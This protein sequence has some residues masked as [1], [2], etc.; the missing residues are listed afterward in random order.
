MWF[1]DP[2]THVPTLAAIV[3]ASGVALPQQAQA[4]LRASV[5]VS[6]LTRPVAFI[7]EPGT[8]RRQYIVEQDGWVRVV[9]DGALQPT[10]FLDV[11]PFVSKGGERGLLGLAFAPDYATTGRLWV[12]FTNTEGHTV[13]A[14][15]IRSAAEPLR[16]DSASRVDLLW[17]DGRRFLQQPFA[18]HNGG[19][20]AFGPDGYL[21][22]A[23]G[24]GGSGNDPDHRAQ[25][26]AVL[27][28]KM[29]RL[30][31]R[32]P[33]SDPEGYD[34]PADNP[35]LDGVPV[36]ALPEIWSFGWRNP[37]KFS[38]DDP[39]RGGTG[40]L[41]VAD[42]GQAGWEEVNYEP[43]NRGGRNYGWRNRE[44]AHAH[45]GSRA[46][47]FLPLTDPIAEYP[48]AQGQAITGGYV[49]RGRALGTE[50]L[51]RYFF[52]DF[53]FGRVWSV[54]LSIAS[55][56]EALASDLQ[57]H[58]GALGDSSALGQISAFGV[59]AAGELYIVSHN[60]GEIIEIGSTLPP[61]PP[62]PVTPDA[63]DY[64]P[65][66]TPPRVRLRR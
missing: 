8:T 18:N 64:E 6:G 35:F 57:E 37:W 63:Q 22:I 9:Q 20:L 44:G 48:R 4:E 14:R 23:L 45:V 29:L 7:R 51:G 10:L 21:Y 28:G 46:P 36:P 42:V 54:A 47:A 41:L 24:D 56:G 2:R 19:T 13:I 49:Y 25:N 55:D 15:F 53:V 31:V 61:L 52:A 50:Y 43:A 3:L 5:R 12:N 26:P 65:R 1:G 27:L 66:R 32:V 30:D 62:D 17:P 34:V 39:A 16:A 33:D 60:R 40:A 38:F 11:S 59:D 58:T